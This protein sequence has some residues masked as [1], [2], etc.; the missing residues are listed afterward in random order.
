MRIKGF[1]FV[2]R[3][4]SVVY[5]LHT[6]RYVCNILLDSD[7]HV[8]SNWPFS[9]ANFASSMQHVKKQADKFFANN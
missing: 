4:C 3:F 9:V 8:T 7:W 6:T 5:M 1:I 2:K